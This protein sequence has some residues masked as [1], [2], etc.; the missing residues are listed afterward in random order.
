MDSEEVTM[1]DDGPAPPLT[2][3]SNVIILDDARHP[4]QERTHARAR[5]PLARTCTARTRSGRG[6][7]NAPI[8]GATVC[9]M[10]GG[11]A[12]QVK[13]A[14][15]IRLLELIAPA[16]AT[17]AREMATAPFSADRQRAANSILDRAGVVKQGGPDADLARTLLIE[18]LMTLKET[19]Q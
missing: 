5:A 14:A 1:S 12:P 6:C 9:R 13:R 8:D 10:H 4:M 17:L 15:Q 16:I 19:G 7:R 2:P 11:A 3:V 18:R